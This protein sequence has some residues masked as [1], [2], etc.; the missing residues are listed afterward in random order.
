MI[1]ISRS[2]A[3]RPVGH[4]A[5][6]RLDQARPRRRRRGS[7]LTAK[8]PRSKKRSF[9]PAY[10]QSSSQQP[11]SPSTQ[12][13]RRQQVVVARHRRLGRRRRT[14]PAPGRRRAIACVVGRRDVDAVCPGR[15]GVGLRHP[16]PVEH[17]GDGRSA[18][19]APGAGDAASPSSGSCATPR[20]PGAAAVDEAGDQRR[21]R[22]RRR[23]RPRGRRRGRPPGGPPRCSWCRSMP[24][25][26]GVL[27]GG[28]HDEALAGQRHPVVAVGDAAR[29]GLDRA[30]PARPAGHTVEQLVH[31]ST[32]RR[33][34]ARSALDGA[35]ALRACP[36]SSGR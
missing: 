32:R 24:E 14:P 13:V 21:P 29:E 27:A 17:G 33:R 6:V 22:A 8:L 30:C 2:R 15:G 10:S 4:R 20:R 5:E 9:M 25:Q 34:A 11:P 16:V 18:V 1:F 36:G 3:R 35:P 28:A 26:V 23:P 7:L 31:G 19:D 12:E